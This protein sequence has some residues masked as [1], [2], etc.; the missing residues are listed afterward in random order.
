MSANIESIPAAFKLDWAAHTLLRLISSYE[1]N[2]VLD[3]GSG[4]GEHKRF[5]EYFG[6]DVFS[7][8]IQRNADYVGDFM[9]VEFDR[10][11]DCIWCSHVLEHQRNVGLFLDKMY[12]LLDEDGVLAITVPY[13]PRERLISGHITSWSIPLLCYNLIMAGFDCSEAKVMAAFEVALIVRKKEAVHSE[14]RNTSAQGADNVEPFCEITKFFPFKAGQ[15]ATI[16]GTAVINWGNPLE[17]D[18][19]NIG[20]GELIINSKN[21]DAIPEMRPKVNLV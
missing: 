16:T 3:I 8:D 19:P 18:L 14:A 17:Y 15:G 7:V 9:E 13:H 2:S 12:D 21:F 10:K 11:F 20:G 5:M 6:K 4:E 1:F